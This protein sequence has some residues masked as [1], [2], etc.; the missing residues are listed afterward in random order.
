MLVIPEPGV[1]GGLLNGE[2]YIRITEI[3]KWVSRQ[4]STADQNTLFIYWFLN[5]KF[6]NFMIHA[7]EIHFNTFETEARGGLRGD[8]DTWQIRG[9]VPVIQILS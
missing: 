3:E 9:M 6:Q 5:I 7:N 4:A 2:A 8:L 1:L